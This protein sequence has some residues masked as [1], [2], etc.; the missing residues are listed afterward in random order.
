MKYFS[1]LRLYNLN[2]TIFIVCSFIKAAYN[3]VPLLHPLPDCPVVG[4]ARRNLL[5]LFPPIITDKVQPLDLNFFQSVVH[6]KAGAH[7]Y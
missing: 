2:H 3:L 6:A 5:V 7:R 1:N 4:R